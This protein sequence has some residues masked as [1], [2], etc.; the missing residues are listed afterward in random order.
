MG[1]ARHGLDAP[2]PEAH[3]RL[4]HDRTHVRAEGDLNADVTHALQ[5]H[6]TANSA[7]EHGLRD[8]AFHSRTLH[9]AS[10]RDGVLANHLQGDT[11]I[12]LAHREHPLPHAPAPGILRGW[13]VK[14]HRLL[15]WPAAHSLWPPTTIQGSRIC[16]RVLA[17]S[18]SSLGARD[19]P[20]WAVRSTHRCRRQHLGDATAAAATRQPRLGARPHATAGGSSACCGCSLLERM[21][22]RIR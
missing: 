4:G 8:S 3:H 1:R 18:A 21:R 5:R 7:P 12:R 17:H 10:D 15:D 11:L 20:I 2:M 19:R 6:R 22:R 9:A 13:R 14:G 16:A